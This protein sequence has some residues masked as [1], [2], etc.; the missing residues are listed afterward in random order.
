MTKGLRNNASTLL[1]MRSGYGEKRIIE[2]IHQGQ[3][4]TQDLIRCRSD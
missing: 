1:P 4:A 3:L 2:K